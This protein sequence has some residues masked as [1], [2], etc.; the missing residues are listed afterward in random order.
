MK[1]RSRTDIVAKILQSASIK[2]ISKTRL[3]YSTYMAYESITP[4]IAMLIENELLNY[5]DQTRLFSTTEKGLRFLQLYNGM[6]QL[7]N[8]EGE[9]QQLYKKKGYWQNV[10]THSSVQPQSSHT[11]PS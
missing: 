9:Q 8:L 4:Y 10:I 3:M 6:R 2:P 11:P 5:D 7:V 1:Y